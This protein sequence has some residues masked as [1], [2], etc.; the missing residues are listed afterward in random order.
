MGG[1]GDKQHT[2]LT[3]HAPAD[4]GR[5]LGR[6]SLGDRVQ[7]AQG[8]PAVLQNVLAVH[9]VLC[10]REGI[11]DVGAVPA[12]VKGRDDQ[13]LRVR[14]GKLR[15]LPGGVDKIPHVVGGLWNVGYLKPQLRADRHTAVGGG[16]KVKS[17]V[18]D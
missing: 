8:D 2:V 15:L 9:D 13:H 4:G 14:G 16:R 11:D 3:A 5:R 6:F 10:D 1:G 12:F 18:L 7:R 17:I